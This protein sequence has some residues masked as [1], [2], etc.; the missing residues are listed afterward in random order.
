MVLAAAA[1]L[2]VAVHP[3]VAQDLHLPVPR[4]TLYPGDVIGEE[5]LADRAFIAHTVARASVF[6]GREG[7]LGKVARRTLL[8]GQP[9]PLNAIRDPYVVMQG[10]AAMVVFEFGGLTITSH[11]TALQ[12]GGIGEVVSLRNNDSGAVIKG[13]VAADGTVRL[14]TP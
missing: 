13:T 1:L 6:E 14:A 2:A 11:A 3:A 8:P 12:N 4:A 9:I 10:K 5:Q 7:L